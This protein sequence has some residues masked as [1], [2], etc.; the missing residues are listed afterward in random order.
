MRGL[1]ALGG[2]RRMLGPARR[3]EGSAAETPEFPEDLSEAEKDLVR[4]VRPFTMTGLERIVQLARSVEY[5][6]RN[7]VA[8][9]IV[10]CGVWRG[11]SMMCVA[12]TL[13]RLGVTDRDL[14]LFDTFD[15]MPSPEAVDTRHDGVA[16]ATV[17]SMSEKSSEDVNWAFAT[18]DQVRQNMRRTG[19][20]EAR[21]HF[22]RGKVEDTIPQG[23]PADISLLRLDTDW[24]AS[25]RHELVHLYPRLA[26]NG[27]LIIDDYGWWQGAKRAVDEYFGGLDFAPLLNRIDVTGRACVKP[28]ALAGTTGGGR[29]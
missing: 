7:R 22:V 11:G 17:L 8:G 5:I 21:M 10:E 16:A 14:Y 19:Y 23:A 24:Y 29:R 9:A 2:V 28:S 15:G 25:T 18:L 12:Y 4:Q 6:V 20:P 13:D 26:E 3:G 27:V 1:K